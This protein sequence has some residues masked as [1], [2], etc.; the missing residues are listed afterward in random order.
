MS[1]LSNWNYRKSITL[2]RASGVV[3]NYQMKLLVGE[4]AGAT[5][6][7]VD[8]NSHCQSGFNDIRFT[9]SDGI[10][11]LDYWVE[12]ITGISPNQL[13]TIWIKFDSIG[14]DATTFYMYYGLSTLDDPI[15]TPATCQ[16]KRYPSN[17]VLTVGAGGKWDDFWVQFNTIWKEGSTYYGYYQGAQSD[18]LFRIGL[19]TST[20]GITWT[21]DTTADGKVLDVGGAGTWDSEQVG[22]PMV[23]KEGATWY[24]LYAGRKAATGVQS[25]G[26]ATSSDGI[27]WD[28]DVSWTN[29][30]YVSQAAWDAKFM[31]PGTRM[32]KEG[33]TYY[34]YYGG[35]DASVLETSTAIG[36]ATSDDLITWTAS[37]NNPILST[38][39][40]GAWDAAAL[41]PT[42]MKFGSTYYMWY[43]GAAGG[44]FDNSYVGLATSSLKDSDWS[45]VSGNPILGTGGD[46]TWDNKWSEVGVIVDFGTEWR[47]Y[48]GGSKGSGTT[49]RCQAGF[50]TYAKKGI[51]ANTFIVFD[52]FE[53]VPE[54]AIG[55]SWT[56]V[57]GS[58]TISMVHSYG[59]RTRS[60]LLP[61]TTD[62]TIPATASNN[63]AIRYRIH[64]ENATGLNL[65][66]GNGTKALQ[67][68]AKDDEHVDFYNGSSYTDL[69]VLLT[70]DI[71]QLMEVSDIVWG[72][73]LDV[74][75]ND[76]NV[77][78]DGACNW[79]YAGYANVLRFSLSGATSHFAD[80][81]VRNYRKVE[82]AWGVWGE[83]EIIGGL[84]KSI[85]RPITINDQIRNI[86]LRDI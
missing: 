2:S 58:P 29:P 77:S 86:G 82:P 5:G 36:L 7:D 56:V 65:T 32:V 12:S 73:S 75:V 37:G 10:T 6:E 52:D 62:I 15:D 42:V 8:C 22:Y 19:A 84:L 18:N 63:I 27:A 38:G 14:T 47:M 49:P 25:I 28:K 4:S 26:L 69:G 43:E 17:P 34:L 35:N 64:K 51:G 70:N 30:V 44:T 53:R 72:T 67:V 85:I 48:Y 54:A 24:M 40:A 16:W 66:H 39:G 41:G 9:T 81:I 45:K 61:V 79:T 23:W 80:L 31:E 57:A 78:D 1:W 3:T 11:L 71:W 83:E 13:A 76:S 74:A 68:R 60:V 50:A 20:D 59:G 55:G 33:S 46:T 21:K